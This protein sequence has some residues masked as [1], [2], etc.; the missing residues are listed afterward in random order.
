[1]CGRMSDS[2]VMEKLERPMALVF[3]VAMRE[4]M[5]IQVGRYDPSLPV[6]EKAGLC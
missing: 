5:A 1:M 4:V 2:S 6:K 3:L